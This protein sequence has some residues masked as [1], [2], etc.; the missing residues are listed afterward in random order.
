MTAFAAKNTGY[1][2][3]D[4]WSPDM[5]K[6]QGPGSDDFGFIPATDAD[7]NIID[8]Y[9]NSFISAKDAKGHRVDISWRELSAKTLKSID[10]E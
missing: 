2:K 9:Y 6:Q 8:G 4:L 7:G 3:D 10:E 1:T 5:L